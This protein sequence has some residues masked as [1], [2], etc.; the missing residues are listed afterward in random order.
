MAMLRILLY[1]HVSMKTKTQQFYISPTVW[2]F[3]GA[4]ELHHIIQR[5]VS[6]LDTTTGSRQSQTFSN[7][8][9]NGRKGKTVRKLYKN[10]SFDVLQLS[11]VPLTRG[12]TDR[13][14]EITDVA[15]AA[16]I[17]Q[18]TSNKKKKLFFSIFCAAIQI[19]LH[20]FPKEVN[21]RL[22]LALLLLLFLPLPGT[23]RPL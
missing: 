10:L 1:G 6:V 18:I 9:H 17:L 3:C 7:S 20:V 22:V 8:T 12:H 2:S 23:V 15:V 13:D 5:G 11:E 21:G 16:A 19:F 14:A 4:V